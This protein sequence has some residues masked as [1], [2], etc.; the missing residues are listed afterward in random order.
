MVLSSGVLV[1][2]EVSS[3]VETMRWV[4]SWGGAA[5][6]LSPPELREATRLEVEKPLQSIAARACRGPL[7][8]GRSAGETGSLEQAE[9][10]V[11]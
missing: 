11:A 5:E 9:S 1:K 3:T 8:E 4:L 10:R 7:A 6:A 2:A